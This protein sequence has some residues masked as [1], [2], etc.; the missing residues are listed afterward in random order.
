[1]WTSSSYLG[2][3]LGPSIGGILIDNYGFQEAAFFFSCLFCVTLMI[4]FKEF[5]THTRSRSKEGSGDSLKILML[6][7][8]ILLQI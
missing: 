3:F 5:L 1:M 6:L 7:F 4:D 2:M 8:Q